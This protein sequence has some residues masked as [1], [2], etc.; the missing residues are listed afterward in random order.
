MADIVQ[1]PSTS[2]EESALWDK[3]CDAQFELIKQAYG[4]EAAAC[5]NY[6]WVS[7]GSEEFIELCTKVYLKAGNVSITSRAYY[8][9][10]TVEHSEFTR[11]MSVEERWREQ[12]AKQTENRLA[13]AF[14]QLRAD[15][16]FA[17]PDWQCCQTCGVNAVPDEKSG[18][19]CFLSR[20]GR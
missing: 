16:Y 5:A 18:L 3:L 6:G 2:Q 14:E 15:G 1:F 11:I 10:G 19:V 12:R 7:G 20:P 13:A 8:Q 17:Q 4:E 9:S